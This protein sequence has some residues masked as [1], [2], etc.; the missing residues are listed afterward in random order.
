VHASV[1]DGY[2]QE[3]RFY[4]NWG[5][6]G[7]N[8]GKY[9]LNLLELKASET[10]TYNFI[11]NALILTGIEPDVTSGAETSS[12]NEKMRIWPVPA[13]DELQLDLS[14]FGEGQVEIDILNN[15]GIEFTRMLNAGKHTTI[16]LEGLDPGIYF[17][18]VISKGMQRIEKFV[19]Q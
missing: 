14:A 19:I 15:L 9:R 10:L 17:L 3:G 1:F 5:L 2:D 7:Y 13:S 12:Q 11:R 18:R 8:N 16:S 4:I 6:Y